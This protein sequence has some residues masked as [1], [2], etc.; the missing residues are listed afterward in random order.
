MIKSTLTAIVLSLPPLAAQ[1]G[2]P[3]PI[4]I[5]IVDLG[6]PS[7]LDQ[8]TL[9]AE[10]DDIQAWYG[11]RSTQQSSGRLIDYVHPNSLMERAG[12]TAGGFITKI[13]GAAVEDG[14]TFDAIMD[15]ISADD[16]VRF[17]VRQDGSTSD[18]DVSVGA[19]DPFPISI[20]RALDTRDCSAGEI[21]IAG[22]LEKETLQPYFY[23]ANHRFRCEDAH[24]GLANALPPHTESEAY[25][26]RGSRR[27]I[28]AMPPWGT[29]C[30]N[31]SDVRADNRSNEVLLQVIDRVADD[32]I[33]DRHA[34]P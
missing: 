32:Y 31:V 9:L 24:V 13:N 1:A 5:S 10:H 25:I 3:C 2:D 19:I 4:T 11:F 14:M 6:V 23:D 30:V 16:E 22:D 29:T 15:A 12:L 28:I 20:A 27:I 21:K 17:T 33:A 26:L 7:W 18:Y 34:N 8:G